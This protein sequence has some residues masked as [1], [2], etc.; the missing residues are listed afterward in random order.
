[1]GFHWECLGLIDIEALKANL[2]II[3]IIIIIWVYTVLGYPVMW[4]KTAVFGLDNYR[5][6]DRY[7]FD[8]FFRPS[9]VDFDLL[10][11][12]SKHRER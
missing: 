1:M 7:T 10:V 4:T 5:K 8:L 12:K 11:S 9:G 3:I 6:R 2:V